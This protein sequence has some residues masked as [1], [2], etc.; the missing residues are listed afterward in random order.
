MLSVRTSSYGC[1]W[2]VWRA[3]KKLELPSATP[4]AE[5]LRFSRALQTSQAHPYLDIRTLSMNQL[6]N[7]RF[8][9]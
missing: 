7:I 8:S 2:E 9:H 3:L 5:L 1:T 4:R 6:L